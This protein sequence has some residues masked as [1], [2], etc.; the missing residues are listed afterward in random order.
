[1]PSSKTRIPISEDLRRELRILKA[2]RDHRS[3][4]ELVADLVANLEDVSE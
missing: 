3:Y 2:E 4:D 1:M